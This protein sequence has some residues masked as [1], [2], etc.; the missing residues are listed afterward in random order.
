MWFGR[1]L[2]IF[3][4]KISGRQACNPVFR[5]RYYCQSAEEQSSGNI[6]VLCCCCRFFATAHI[7]FQG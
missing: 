6:F 1:M 2:P 3:G 7:A 5:M 4:E